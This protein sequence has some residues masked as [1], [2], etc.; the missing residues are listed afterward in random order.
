MLDELRECVPNIQINETELVTSPDPLGMQHEETFLF[1][2]G[3]IKKRWPAKPRMLGHD[4][5]LHPMAF[6]IA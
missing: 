1:K 6:E 5:T 2:L 4:F 3:P